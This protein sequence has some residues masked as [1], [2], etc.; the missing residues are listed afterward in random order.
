MKIPEK[1]FN[2]LFFL[3][4]VIFL[5]SQAYAGEPVKFTFT[6]PESKVVFEGSSTFHDFDGK[7]SEIS[8]FAE[9]DIENLEDTS[10]GTFEV[11]VVSMT[12][13]HEKRDSNMMED[14]AEKLFPVISFNLTR[15]AILKKPASESDHY[16]VKISGEL[17]MHGVKKDIAFPATMSL[18]DKA[19]N[20]KASVPLSLKDFDIK[21]RTFLF[22]SVKD[23]IK[24][25]FDLT[26]VRI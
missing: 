9:G 1:V 15:I 11:K 19:I 18:S 17:A 2:T 23:Q 16:L 21:P 12:T 3:P 4:I 24:V 14:M 6:S 13:N 22:M 10:K 7:A 26:G 8:G 5:A 20:L 25:D